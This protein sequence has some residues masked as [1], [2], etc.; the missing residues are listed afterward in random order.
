MNQI[1][2]GPFKLTPSLIKLALGFP[3]IDAA[4][5]MRGAPQAEIR[6]TA[7]FEIRRGRRFAQICRSI[8]MLLIC[9]HTRHLRIIPKKTF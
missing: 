9:V 7:G 3:A 8:A 5:R 4:L 6:R 1:T 2:A